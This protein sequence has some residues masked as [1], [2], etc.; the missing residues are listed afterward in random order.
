MGKPSRRAVCKFLKEK[1]EKGIDV[2]ILNSDNLAHGRGVTRKT[3]E[4][5]FSCGA[6]ILTCG[7]HAWD[8]SRAFDILKEG[9]LN[10][11]CPTNLAGQD[12]MLSGNTFEIGGVKILVINLL[13]KIFIDKDVT[14]P[15]SAIDDILEANE[16]EGGA[17]III[18]DFHAEA[19]SEK[20]AL[21]EYLNGRVSAVLGS[22]THVQTADEEILSGKTAYI[23]DSGMTGV[24]DSI[25][26][27]EKGAV[28]EQFLKGSPFKYKLA[29]SSCVR[30]EGVLIS[31]D[32]KTGN[33]EK[34]SRVREEIFIED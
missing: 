21:G 14:S 8:N 9:D 28:L 1:K 13:G 7:D 18:V 12:H 25:L 34:I 27:C 30:I 32:E 24:K 11:I 22:H 10:F 4:E 20:K 3:L 29:E 16:K 31:I 33:A 26:G 23:S 6:D 19:T 5:M 15:F 2:A 17:K